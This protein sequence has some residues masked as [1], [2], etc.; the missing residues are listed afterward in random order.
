MLEGGP[1]DTTPLLREVLNECPILIDY[2]LV[3]GDRPP[4]DRAADFNATMRELDSRM[5]LFAADPTNAFILYRFTAADDAGASMA[6]DGPV[7][8]T[9]SPF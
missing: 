3:M 2:V 5:D 7:D 9:E 1:T 8:R 4:V 6:H